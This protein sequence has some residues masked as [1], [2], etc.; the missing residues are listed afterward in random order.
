M[1][2][3]E[4][5]D[6]TTAA[7]EQVKKAVQQLKT[8]YQCVSEQIV[9]KKEELRLAPLAYIPLDDLKA[10]I[11]EFV[12]KSGVRYGQE[13]IKETI[14]SF[15]TNRMNGIAF[16]SKQVGKPMRY[17]DIEQSISNGWNQLLTPNKTQFNDQVFYCFFAQL[18][19][20]GLSKLMDDMPPEAFGYGQIHP[21]KIGSCRAQRQ[22]EIQGLEKEISELT[23]KRDELSLKLTALG[24]SVSAESGV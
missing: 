5:F 16:D 15:A 4:N 21:D 7:F 1:D 17:C 13:K 19:Q 12:A 3:V 11:L 22:I 2:T 23:L 9:Q 8:E 24:Y 20:Q 14:S 18:V 6:A 10:G